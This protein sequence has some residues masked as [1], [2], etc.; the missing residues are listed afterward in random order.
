[1]PQIILILL[2]KQLSLGC[3]K[4]TKK[5]WDGQWIQFIRYIKYVNERIGICWQKL[6]VVI[7]IFSKL[8]K[9]CVIFY[10]KKDNVMSV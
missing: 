2:M 10:L 6:L 1:V 9:V 8:M 3:L 7:T 4:G 5:T